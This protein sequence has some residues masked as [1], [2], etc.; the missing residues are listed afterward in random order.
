MLFK[1]NTKNRKDRGEESFI[2]LPKFAAKLYDKM[3]QLAPMKLQREQIAKELLDH[4]E[5]GR[6]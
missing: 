2:K 6:L 4:I 1:K 3:M 5:E